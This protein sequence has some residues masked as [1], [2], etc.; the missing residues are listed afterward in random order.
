MTHSELK[1]LRNHSHTLF[2][3]GSDVVISLLDHIDRQAEVIREMREAL[4][5]ILRNVAIDWYVQQFAKSTEPSDPSSG[6]IG[7]I[8]NK[9]TSDRA[10]AAFSIAR[11]VLAKH[12][13]IES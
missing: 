2:K 13:E 1:L 6:I 4:D 11:E 8:H 12:K 5:K 7:L 3:E 10:K 9:D